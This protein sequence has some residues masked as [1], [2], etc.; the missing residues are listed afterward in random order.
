MLDA[1]L[2][3]R[4]L[5]RLSVLGAV[6]GAEIDA[7]LAAD[8]GASGEEGAA[9]CRAALPDAGAKE[10]AWEAMFASDALSNYLLRATAQG[11]WQPEQLGLLGGFVERFFED[12]VPVAARRGAAVG[13][14]VGRFGFPR[15][16]VDE[17]VLRRGAE[18]VGGDGVTPALRRELVDQLDDL[19]RALRVRELHGA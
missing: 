4:L 18:C 7:A 14:I 9:R 1:E 17:S 10:A 11:F 15:T 19:G 8:P 2:R 16:V 5:L 12:A 6:G 13:V 3:W